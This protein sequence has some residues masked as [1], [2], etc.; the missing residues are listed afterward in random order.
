MQLNASDQAGVIANRTCENCSVPCMA[1]MFVMSWAGRPC[2]CLGGG[3]R[4]C[5]NGNQLRGQHQKKGHIECAAGVKQEGGGGGVCDTG[6]GAAVVTCDR[7]WG[8]GNMCMTH[9]T[10]TGKKEFKGTAPVT[11]YRRR[12]HTQIRWGYGTQSN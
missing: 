2:V 12:T 7:Q 8:R 6:G 11:Q 9:S 1:S 3:G 10:A 4:R 5:D